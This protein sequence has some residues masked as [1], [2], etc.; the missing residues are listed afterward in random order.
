MEKYPDGWIKLVLMINPETNEIH[1]IGGDR[2]EGEGD[3]PYTGYAILKKMFCAC[4]ELD[5]I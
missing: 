5:G 2:E 1:C 3:M 4:S